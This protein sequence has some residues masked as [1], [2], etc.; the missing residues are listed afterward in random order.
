MLAEGWQFKDYHFYK[1]HSLACHKAYPIELF[2]VLPMVFIS[3]Y[4][5]RV[6]QLVSLFLGETTL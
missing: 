6:N 5:F 4:L 2:S 3:V 1:S